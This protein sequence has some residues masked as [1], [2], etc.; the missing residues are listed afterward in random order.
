MEIH[1]PKL[2]AG[3]SEGGSEVFMTD[4]F[5]KP[6]CLA[7]SPQLYKQMAAACGGLGRVMEVCLPDKEAFGR[8]LAGWSERGRGAGALRDS[9]CLRWRNMFSRQQSW[10]P[11][12]LIAQK[13]SWVLMD[14]RIEGEAWNVL[15]SGRRSRSGSPPVAPVRL[16][17]FMLGTSDVL[18]FLEDYS[19]S[20]PSRESGVCSNYDEKREKQGK[21]IA[22]G[23]DVNNSAKHIHQSG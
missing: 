22:P 9:V 11:G 19:L 10:L 5:G 14:D 1:T 20:S 16:F 21:K 4:Y 2:L 3:A 15:V 7:Q 13:I 8:W 17:F 23:G 6:A 18:V 12:E